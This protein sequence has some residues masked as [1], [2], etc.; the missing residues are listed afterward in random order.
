MAFARLAE[1]IV[2]AVGSHYNRKINQLVF[3]EFFHRYVNDKYYSL[4]I[5]YK[6]MIIR[7][8]MWG[9]YTIV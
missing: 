1:V 7:G 4:R 5:N 2:P 8:A 3:V 9:Y 6:Y